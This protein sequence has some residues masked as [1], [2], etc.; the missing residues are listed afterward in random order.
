M[1]TFC[2]HLKNNISDIRLIPLNHVTYYELW[3]MKY[4][5]KLFI[6]CF[7]SLIKLFHDYCRPISV[8]WIQTRLLQYFMTVMQWRNRRGCR[9]GGTVHTHHISAGWDPSG[10]VSS[11]EYM[12]GQS[13]STDSVEPQ[14]SGNEQRMKWGI[15]V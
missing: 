12:N 11:S 14:K 10:F 15:K 9:V 8:P 6:K 2:P 3:Q 1:N 13:G 7:W 5:F 4:E